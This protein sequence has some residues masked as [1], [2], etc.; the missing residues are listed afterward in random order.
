[1]IDSSHKLYFDCFFQ[2]TNYHKVVEGLGASGILL[3]KGDNIPE[4][5][6]EARKLQQE[7]KPV[8]INALIGKSKFREG[9]IS[10]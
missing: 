1:M 2:Y 5:L 10:V 3:E 6:R 4:K 7:G 9:S 8:V